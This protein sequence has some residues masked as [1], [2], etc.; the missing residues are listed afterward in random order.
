MKADVSI[1]MGKASPTSKPNGAAYGRANLIF[2]HKR[3]QFSG[4]DFTANI[5]TCCNIAAWAGQANT[6]YSLPT[7]KQL[8]EFYIVTFFD[9]TTNGNGAAGLRVEAPYLSCRCRRRVNAH[10]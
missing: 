6:S 8:L 4:F 7:F 3:V 2:V 1:F 5:N 9:F 10:K